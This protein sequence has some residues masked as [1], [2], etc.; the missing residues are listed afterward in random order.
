MPQKSP[1]F[2]VDKARSQMTAEDLQGFDHLCRFNPT[3]GDIQG[4]LRELG[5]IV[6]HS[7]VQSWFTATYPV[8]DEAKVI[9]ALTMTYAGVEPY[10]ALQMSMSIAVSLTDTLMKHCDESRLASASAGDLMMTVGNLLKEM[11]TCARVLQDFKV[12][13]DRKALELAGGYR[14]IEI[15]RHLAEDSPMAN[16]IA[17]FCDAAIGQLEQEVNG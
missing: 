1:Q 2:D 5:H 16:N 7:A 15:L 9:N 17:D 13:R 3:Y 8:G 10:Q 12:T 11:R 4:R 14:V 6:S